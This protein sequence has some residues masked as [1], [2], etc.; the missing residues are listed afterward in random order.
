MRIVSKKTKYCLTA[1][2][3]LARTYGSGPVLVSTLAEQGGMPK[4]FLE[5]ILLVMKIGGIV[6]SKAGRGGGYQLSKPPEQ[7]TIGSIIRMI[8]GPLAPLPCAS[9]TAYHPC[10]E[11]IDPEN[12]GTRLVMRRVRDAT[13]QI[14]D[15]TTLADVCQMTRKNT[16]VPL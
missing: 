1:L 8:E 9:E 11:C 10:E 13:A 14:L 3:S 15:Q 2:Y 16:L 12:C 5:Q 6:Q 7:I 4:K